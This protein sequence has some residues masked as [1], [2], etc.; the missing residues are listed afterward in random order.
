LAIAAGFLLLVGLI[1]P[2]AA[3]AVGF[4]AAATSASIIPA[5]DG[6]ATPSRLVFAFVAVIATAVVVLGPGAFSIDAR[7]FGLRE[8]IIPP[9]RPPQ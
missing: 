9:S 5:I 1:T 4:I 6:G 2:I 7:L 3:A 8:I